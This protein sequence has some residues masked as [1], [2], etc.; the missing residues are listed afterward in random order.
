MSIK[1]LESKCQ[2][3]RQFQH[4]IEEAQAEAQVIKDHLKAIVGDSEAVQAV[5]Y[6]NTAAALKSALPEVLERF[7]RT[8]TTSRVQMA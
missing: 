7:T 1:E 3:L 5:E 2:A 4:L 6:K 8:S